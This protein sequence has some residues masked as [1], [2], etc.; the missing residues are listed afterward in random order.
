MNVLIF[1]MFRVTM[2]KSFVDAAITPFYTFEME[3]S[4]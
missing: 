1:T 2:I 4:Y 3:Q